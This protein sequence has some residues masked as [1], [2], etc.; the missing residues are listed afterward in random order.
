[1]EGE[2]RRRSGVPHVRRRAKTVPPPAPSASP[3]RAHPR[4]RPSPIE[5]EGSPFAPQPFVRRA[6]GTSK[7]QPGRPEPAPGST[8]GPDPSG[9]PPGGARSRVKSAASLDGAPPG[10]YFRRITGRRP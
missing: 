5:G 4:P 10:G 3:L 2:A 7:T 1:M 8:R 6:A 9:Q